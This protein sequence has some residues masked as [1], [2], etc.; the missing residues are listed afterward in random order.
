MNANV[1]GRPKSAVGGKGAMGRRYPDRPVVGVSGVVICGDEVLVVKRG[2]A[3]SKGLWSLPGGA[4][5]L[6]ERLSV[7]CAREVLEETGVPVEV[8]PLVEVFERLLRD[9][10]GRVEYHYVLLDYLC[11]AQRVA[12]TAG[13]DADEARWALIEEVGDL[14]LTPDTLEVIR[15]AQAMNHQAWL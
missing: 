4:V 2:R 12:P 1:G 13:D 10:T 5:E 8:G 15:K 9:E 7:A 11:R 3:P 6:G 14:G